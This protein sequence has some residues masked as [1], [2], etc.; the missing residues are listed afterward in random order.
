MDSIKQGF[1]AS[2]AEAAKS[3]FGLSP[4]DF[5]LL[6]NLSA[7]TFERRRKGDKP[8]DPVASERLD[9]LAV[10]AVLAEDVFEDKDA[11]ARWL[12]TPNHALGGQAP[13]LHCDTEIGAR[14]V[15]RILRAIEWGGVA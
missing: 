11:A 14:Q 1:S 5:G 10:V 3:A 12:S 7:S 9:R 8:L 2:W 4:S 6:L 13:V 15:R